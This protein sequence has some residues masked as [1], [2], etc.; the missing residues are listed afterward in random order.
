MMTLQIHKSQ[1]ARLQAE[2]RRAGRREIGGVLA[3]ENLGDTV[4]RLVDFS[5]QRSG[6]GVACFVRKPTQHRR[7]MTKFFKATGHD[8]ARFNYIGEWHSHPM[9]PA[10]PSRVDLRQMQ[11]IV[12]DAE[13]NA[14]FAVLLVVRLGGRD[15]LEA[16]AC[17][18]RRGALPDAVH[19]D[20]VASFQRSQ[21]SDIDGE[22]PSACRCIAG[23][24]VQRSHEPE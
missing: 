17:A 23:R 24:D 3:A 22:Q 6:G 7:F 5:V 4:F 1:V 2:L 11:E 13:Q 20:V 14:L 12:E 16:S 18:F 21:P 8:Y 15:V 19:I 10:H 9:F